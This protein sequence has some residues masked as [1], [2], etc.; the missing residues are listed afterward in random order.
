[1][2]RSCANSRKATERSRAARSIR[3]A[4]A[5]S[6]STSLLDRTVTIA[7]AASISSIKRVASVSVSCSPRVSE[8]TA[9]FGSMLE[10]FGPLI[11][12]VKLNSYI[13][14]AVGSKRTEVFDETD[15]FSTGAAIIYQERTATYRVARYSRARAAVFQSDAI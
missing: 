13:T 4:M 3:S 14:E 2:R 8:R 7:S 1:M 15:E 12:F 6:E 9:V 11:G 10:I 5:S